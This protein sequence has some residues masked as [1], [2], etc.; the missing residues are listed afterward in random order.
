MPLP[1]IWLVNTQIR[2]E[3]VEIFVSKK[4]IRKHQGPA[5]R[6]LSCL[7]D[8]VLQIDVVILLCMPPRNLLQLQ[9]LQ[10]HLELSHSEARAQ[11]GSE[12]KKRNNGSG[13]LLE[14]TARN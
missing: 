12:P 2:K 1:R 4:R 8:I 14:R 3:Y 13:D 6:K 11:H 5:D 7:I 9:Q 10:T